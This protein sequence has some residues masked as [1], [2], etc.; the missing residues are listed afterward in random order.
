MGHLT[1][2]VIIFQ[3]PSDHHG[4][5]FLVGSNIFNIFGGDRPPVLEHGDPIADLTQL[6]HLMRDINNTHA[7]FLEA[8]DNLK[9]VF[10]LIQ[11]ERG[12]RLVHDQHLC[13]RGQRLCDFNELLL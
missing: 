10:H 5:D 9:Q 7:A 1:V 4:D 11:I 2:K 12:G 3:L 13:V 6:P 8:A